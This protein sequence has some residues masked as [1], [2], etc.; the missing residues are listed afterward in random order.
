MIFNA[1]SDTKEGLFGI[2]VKSAGHIFAKKGRKISRP[3]GREDW[4]LFYVS[5][6]SEHFY[7]EREEDAN[8]GSFIFFRPHE[9][10]EHENI[11]DRT[12]EFYYI[13]FLAPETFDLFGLESSKIYSSKTS[14]SVRDIF[15]SIISELQTKQ[16]GYEKICA[17]KLFTVIAELS[18]RTVKESDPNRTY[19]DRIAFVIQIMNREYEKQHSLEDFADMCK[20]S[21]FHFLRIFKEITGSS[22]VE[23]KNKIR[24][25][26]ALEF[27]EDGG[28]PIGEIAAQVG[29]SSPAY[30]CDAFKK[31]YGVSP[32]AYRKLKDANRG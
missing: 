12:G 8:E 14:A 1:Y 9:M 11:W 10:Q 21:K 17:A 4:L 24:M 26:H 32:S 19:A 23:Y 7:F 16:Y 20:M 15:E 22:P 25:D 5:K 27:L 31:K 29:F 30:F 18:R 13:H 28:T 3:G 6:G 2:S